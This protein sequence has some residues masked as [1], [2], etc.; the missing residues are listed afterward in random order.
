MCGNSRTDI[1][2]SEWEAERN[3]HPFIVEK[4][5][6][7]ALAEY[8]DGSAE[9]YS[10]TEYKDIRERIA[11][12][13]L[14]T[15]ILKKDRRMLDIGC[16]P[17]L[18]EVLFSPHLKEVT[19]IDGS[20]KMIERLKEECSAQ[21]CNN[22]RGI[23]EQWET[24]DTDERYDI[25]FSSLCPPLNNPESLLKME[26]YSSDLCIYVSSANTSPSIQTKIWKDLGKEY[27]FGGYNTEYPNRYLL[28]IGRKPVLK[29]YK[30]EH[31]HEM[32]ESEAVALYER[33]TERYQKTTP[34]VHDI[35]ASAVRSCSS[36]GIFR[37]KRTMTL[38]MLVWKVKRSDP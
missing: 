23:V 11:N 1:I 2:C 18:Y 25:V 16:G 24:F 19:G 4:L 17:G 13:L 34:D 30:E 33:N 35:I 38:G 32:P 5:S 15:G 37:E 31:V 7:A 20:K 29:F 36:D 22:V 8:W 26:S 14:E 10:G 21:S 28:S 3:K 9:K 27:S 6:P 12:D